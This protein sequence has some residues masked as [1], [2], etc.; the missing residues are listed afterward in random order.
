[1]NKYKELLNKER[2]VSDVLRMS[3]PGYSRLHSKAHRLIEQGYPMKS[4][5]T[6]IKRSV[7]ECKADN[8]YNDPI[9]YY[10]DNEPYFVAEK[11][12]NVNHPAHYTDGEIEVIDYIEDKRFPY[13]LGNAVKYIS[14]AGKKDPDKT[15]EDLRKAVW[16]I[17]RY[18]LFIA[19]DEEENE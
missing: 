10:S 3:V 9:V 8:Q 18:I 4:V 16:Y 12:D 7:N 2:K 6:I 15:V 14:R 13:H 19:G 5:I 11:P 17:E 1:M